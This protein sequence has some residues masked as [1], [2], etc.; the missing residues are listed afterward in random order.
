[1]IWLWHKLFGDTP[2]LLELKR[3]LNGDREFASVTVSRKAQNLKSWLPKLSARE[4]SAALRFARCL[5]RESPKT[6]AGL[7][8][9][10]GASAQEQP[11]D[12]TGFFVFDYNAMDGLYGK[13]AFTAIY[14]AL[15]S[16]SG[17][18]VF[19]DG[20]IFNC[21]TVR[22]TARQANLVT[23]SSPKSPLADLGGPFEFGAYFAVMWTD[24]HFNFKRIHESLVSASLLGYLGYV[25][26]HGRQSPEDFIQLAFHQLHLPQAIIVKDGV[27]AKSKYGIQ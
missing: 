1:M 25:T 5:V 13:Q 19:H 27:V 21:E 14:V 6:T 26:L 18:C 9:P 20:D 4:R 23:A 11:D 16:S 17:V 10:T 7:S 12:T 8:Q 2:K 3:R 15:R 24:T 22:D